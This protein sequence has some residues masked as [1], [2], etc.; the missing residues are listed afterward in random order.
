MTDQTVTVACDKAKINESGI[1]VLLNKGMEG[2]D[3]F[4]NLLALFDQG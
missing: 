4:Y 3:L 1:Q 2:L